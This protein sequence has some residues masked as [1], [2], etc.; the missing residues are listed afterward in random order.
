MVPAT[1]TPKMARANQSKLRGASCKDRNP[2]AGSTTNGRLTW[3]SV[4]E[5]AGIAICGACEAHSNR[6]PSAISSVNG[7]K[8]LTEALNQ[9]Q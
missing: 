8:N 6:S 4:A 7:T 1:Q 9:S 3:A 5:T 2:T